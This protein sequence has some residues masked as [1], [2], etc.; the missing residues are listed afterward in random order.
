MLTA[1]S[2]FPWLVLCLRHCECACVRYGGCLNLG[3]MRSLELSGST[4]DQCSGRM[5][6]ARQG[7]WRV[8]DV[9][10]PPLIRVHCARLLFVVPLPLFSQ[11]PLVALC[12]SLLRLAP[13]C[14]CKTFTR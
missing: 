12:T 10:S 3:I 5:P 9:C 7:A 2:R 13:L 8:L 11:V 14:S 1:L 4:F 6:G